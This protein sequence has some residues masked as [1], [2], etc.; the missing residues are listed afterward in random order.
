LSQIQRCIHATCHIS[1][2]MYRCIGAV[3]TLI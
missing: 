3:L 2:D 1:P